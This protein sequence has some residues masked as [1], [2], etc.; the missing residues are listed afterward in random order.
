AQQLLFDFGQA[1]HGW[2]SAEAAADQAR[3]SER[4]TLLAVLQDVRAAYFDAQAKKAI[5]R[6]Q[7]ETLANQEKHRDQIEQSV[8]VGIRPT[9][10]LAQARTDYANAQV[11]LIN[12]ESDYDAARAKLNQV[13]GREGSVDYDIGD[14]PMPPLSN[15]DAGTE[16]LVADALTARPEIA[17]QR[18]LVR[19]QEETVSRLR[20]TY[21]PSLN[22]AASLTDGG[23][24]LDRLAWNWNAQLLLTW[25]LFAGGLNVGQVE[26]AQAALAGYGAQIDAIR[27]QVRLD[28]EQARLGVRATKAALGAA[29]DALVNAARRLELAEGRYSTGIGNGI[30]LGDAQVAHTAAA[31]QKVQAAYKLAAA[32]AT[33]LTALGHL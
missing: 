22:A 28:V 20:G 24:Q 11:A 25:P 4:A 23:V 5:V 16:A 8:E 30:E 9:I 31:A 1:Y 15:E 18:A 21:W 7:R 2:S 33:L 32:R 17:A 6:V 13:I 27:Q 19:A 14:D 3:S 10:D 29:D 12:A 26:E